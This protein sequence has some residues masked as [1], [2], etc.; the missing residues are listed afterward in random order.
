MIDLDGGLAKRFSIG[1]RMHLR[2][3]RRL[4]RHQPYELC[5][6]V[7]ELRE[8]FQ[9]RRFEYRD[10]A[11]GGRQPHGANRP[12]HGFLGRRGRRP[13][14]ATCSAASRICRR[15][16]LSRRT[17]SARKSRNARPPIRNKADRYVWQDVVIGP[18][19]H[20][21]SNGQLVV[22]NADVLGLRAGGKSGAELAEAAPISVCM[23]K[24]YLRW[25]SM[26]K[27]GPKRNRCSDIAGLA[28]IPSVFG[29]T[30]RLP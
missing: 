27:F 15:C 18:C 8:P 6:A 30:T 13:F 10:A 12:A 17:H 9:L 21:Q 3:R 19:A 11:G 5:A 28:G 22:V 24:A 26:R 23:P 4:P 2:S 7:A 20:T 16:Q 1:E 29:G 14:W 25:R